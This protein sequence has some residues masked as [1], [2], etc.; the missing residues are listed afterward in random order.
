MSMPTRC[1]W[2]PAFIACIGLRLFF[3]GPF[4]LAHCV[5]VTAHS[6]PVKVAPD[7]CQRLTLVQVTCVLTIMQGLHDFIFE[8]S[9]H[10]HLLSP[11]LSG[12]SAAISPDETINIQSTAPLLP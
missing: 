2:Y 10:Q 6:R 12:M 7:S 1:R 3:V 9:R 8:N 11:F 5:H 4:L